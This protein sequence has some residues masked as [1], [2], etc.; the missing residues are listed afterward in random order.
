MHRFPPL[1]LGQGIVVVNTAL[2][3]EITVLVS[4]SMCENCVECLDTR[5]M[6]D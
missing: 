4:V 5:Q 3:D 6:H 2:H 1:H